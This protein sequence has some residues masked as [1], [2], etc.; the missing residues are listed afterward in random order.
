MLHGFM[1]SRGAPACTEGFSRRSL[2]SRS[3]SLECGKTPNHRT[4][5]EEP[6]QLER[7]CPGKKVE[8]SRRPELTW[9]SG[10]RRNESR[11][12]GGRGSYGSPGGWRPRKGKRGGSHGAAARGQR[13][14][15]GCAILR[16]DC[17]LT[18][19]GNNSTHTFAAGCNGERSYPTDA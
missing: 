13:R 11:E 1:G 4:D 9:P 17:G 14:V 18:D 15:Q 6:G 19:E 3:V 12:E 10:P 2:I 16:A 5:G 7:E 8:W